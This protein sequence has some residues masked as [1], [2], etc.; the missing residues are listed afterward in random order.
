MNECYSQGMYEKVNPSVPDGLVHQRKQL[1]SSHHNP[2][3]CLTN[4]STHFQHLQPNTLLDEL[5]RSLRI[6]TI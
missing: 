2:S 3:P 6:P 1:C 5:R 4:Q